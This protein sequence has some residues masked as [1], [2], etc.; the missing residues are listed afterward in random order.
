MKGNSSVIHWE[1]REPVIPYEFTPDWL[2]ELSEMR[3]RVLY[4]QGRRPAFR[5]SNGAF[6]DWNELDVLAYHLI[7]RTQMEVVG[8]IRL[9][10]LGSAPKC[11][12]EELVGKSLFNKAL[13][14][15]QVSRDEAAECGRWIVVPE[16]RNTLLGMHLVAGII[17]VGRQL[18][19]RVLIGPTGIRDGQ[20]TLLARI[21]MQRLPNLPAVE[22][23]QYDDELEFLYLDPCR[24]EQRF[25]RIVNEMATRLAQE[26]VL[27]ELDSRIA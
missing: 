10:P 6:S 25:T 16:H 12:T 20:A 19:Y 8:C 3:G 2:L 4:S 13:Q 15:L 24:T 5:L 22:V 27:P 21:G 18:R 1:L 7:A 11:I 14:N 23:A 26:R 17:A 9:V